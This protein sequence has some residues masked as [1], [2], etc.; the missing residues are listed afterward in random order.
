[1]AAAVQSFISGDTGVV[2]RLP[3]Q[4]SI[5]HG[6]E[7]TLSAWRSGLKSLTVVFDPAVEAPR[8]TTVATRK[9]KAVPMAHAMPITAPRERSRNGNSTSAFV[10]RK[11]AGVKRTVHKAG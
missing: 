9:I 4:Q 6:A 7:V 3:V 8:Q 10:A 11:A 2:V 5:E 1:M